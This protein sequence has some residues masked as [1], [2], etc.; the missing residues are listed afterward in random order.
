MRLSLDHPDFFQN[1]YPFYE[2][3]RETGRPYWIPA[4]RDID[5]KGTW[6]FWRYSDALEIFK[7][8]GGVSKNIVR[9]RD[10]GKSSV[11]DVNMLNMDGE[12]HLRLRRLVKDYFSTGHVRRL[13]PYIE[14]A[15]D[16]LVRNLLQKDSPPDLVPDFAEQLPLRVIASLV[17]IPLEDMSRVRAWS[18]AVSPAFDSIQS[19][20]EA[21]TS[22]KQANLREFIDY[23]EDLIAARSNTPDDSMLSYLIK[24]GK[25]GV[26]TRN[27]LL[28]MT[29]F[30][31]FAGHET[32]INLIGSGLWLLLSHPEQWE[33][34]QNRK[35]LIPNAV[36]EILRFESPT[37]RSTFRIAT[38][39]VEIG[40]FPVEPGQQLGVIIGAANR[41]GDEFR[42]PGV[43][44]I[45][46]NP[47]R[48]L[49]FGFG[50]HNCLGKTLARAEARIALS[51]VL[52]QA[53]ML[54]LV[55]RA[56]QWRKNSFF[57]GLESLP[58]RLA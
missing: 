13:E 27:E 28:G 32:T 25:Q 33:L 48:H 43:F 15:A 20:D 18:L 50:I 53:P 29:A 39:P 55:D 3:I 24:A 16:D 47:N 19:S 23:I 30:M 37:Q 58:A 54:Q 34:L 49:A 42:N 41:D 31:V 10:A 7:L 5:S 26:I 35:D 9:V 1:P 11:F 17:G 2:K 38:E 21:L 6:F 44:D 51:T 36:E 52:E 57:R 46:R 40:G 8:A 22:N 14:S 45:Q 4:D 56:P 12:S